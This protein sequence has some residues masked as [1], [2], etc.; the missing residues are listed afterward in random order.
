MKKFIITLFILI[1]S[2]SGQ[3]TQA[4]RL[5]SNFNNDQN[6]KIE[7]HTILADGDYI[8][9]AW[10][11]EKYLSDT[12]SFGYTSNYGESF[13]FI[14]KITFPNYDFDINGDM[15]L[16]KKD[17]ILYL[18]FQS[19]QSLSSNFRISFLTSENNG[20]DWSELKILTNIFANKARSF[21]VIVKD[22]NNIDIVYESPSQKIF[23]AKTSDGG[24][25]WSNTI[26][27]SSLILSTSDLELIQPSESEYR[28]YGLIQDDAD[29]LNLIEL[30][31][32]D[33]GN[34]W[35]DSKNIAVLISPYTSSTPVNLSLTALKKGEE[36]YFAFENKNDREI[37]SLKYDLNG[38]DVS[39]INKMTTYKGI[40]K[41][42]NLFIENDVV[43]YS[44]ITDKEFYSVEDDGNSSIWIDGFDS[45]NDVYHY[46]YLINPKVTGDYI[47]DLYVK[48]TVEV[49]DL[50]V[51]EV[52]AMWN[53]EKYIMLNNGVYPDT[54][55]YDNIASVQLP[56]KQ[57]NN[58]L[59]IY[60]LDENDN[61][62]KLSLSDINAEP[63][64]A[65]YI[66]DKERLK[67][68]FNNRGI[69]AD[70][71]LNSISG[72]IYD[73]HIVL[74]SA[75]FYMTGLV[76]GNIWANGVLSASRIEDYIP[77]NLSS[78]DESKFS[79]Y[80][81]NKRNPDFGN[82]W[83]LWK[84]A[85][86][87]GAHFYDGD[88]D[89]VYNPVDKNN[90]GKWDLDEDRP[91]L[92]G[93]E[94]YWYVINDGVPKENRRFDV[95][96]LG[97]EIRTTLFTSSNG[98]S[99]AFD[100][101]IFIRYEIENTGLVSDKL[102]DVYFSFA[103]DADVGEYQDDLVGTDIS[104]SSG[105]TYSEG[106]DAEF[107]VNSPA[108]FMSIL[109]GPIKYWKGKSYEDV[110]GN[111]IYDEGIDTPLDSGIVR[112][113]NYLGEEIYSGAMNQGLQSVNQYMS[114][115]PTHGDPDTEFA[116]R[117][118]QI[119]GRGKE[120][121]SLY[122]TNWYF[123]NGNMLGLDSTLYPSKYMYWGDPETQTGWLNT[124][125]VDQRIM[126]STGPFDLEVGKPKTVLGAL[127][128]ARGTTSANSVTLAKQYWNE[129]KYSYD[130]NF[131]DIPV[132]VKR[133]NNNLP[134]EFSLSQ[135]Y[136]NPFN[137]T[138]SIEYTIPN[139]ET[140]RAASKMQNV[141]LK[142]FDILGREV[143]VLVNEQQ[144]AGKY[145]V[146]FNAIDLSSGVYIYQLKSGSN[147]SAKKMMLIK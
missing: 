114:S 9:A 126:I 27:N 123:G 109:E 67:L 17:G 82:S 45:P 88:N 30:I 76:N 5:L 142:V 46:P 85:V 52:Y 97:I 92:I 89:G 50:D 116:L 48:V 47:I 21:D 122:V 139:V 102:E 69:I 146:N 113:G 43:Y 138:T 42:A 33:N 133:E 110:N 125:P 16:I 145:R 57:I 70:V 108:V 34:T 143:K 35:S 8:Y 11:T 127:I 136:P 14:K 40:N 90:N 117:N 61:L 128:V 134:M 66:I 105:F 135:N 53:N 80:P 12:I 87:L 141:S 31:S 62:S 144:S 60:A 24:T 121:D 73:D 131:A 84:D 130:N 38:G 18:F 95:D 20:E 68:P 86:E 29:Q 59:E 94:T 71:V 32:T 115:H 15:R 119:G 74:F 107:G 64:N 63:I 137:P 22:S 41:G 96:P 7:N 1:T 49:Y 98:E 58:T 77:G 25:N 103:Q 65:N 4:Y 100:N 78:S 81:L 72:G 106:D 111:N 99:E 101:T 124:V 83:Q 6:V 26:I 56:M 23:I 120:G 91:D 36:I 129:I 37:S 93:Q 54:S 2:L 75:G 28:I 10:L 104:S 132:S 39:E 51:I 13:D 147:I 140:L 112:S 19:E 3:V 55:A 44:W 79:I 118:Y